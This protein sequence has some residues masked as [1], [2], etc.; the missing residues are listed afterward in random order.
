M[1]LQDSMTSLNPAFTIGD[2]VAEPIR[3][4]QKIE[5]GIVWQKVIDI[6]RLVRI[7]AAEKR[8]GE[9]PHQMSGGMRQRVSGA[10]AFSCQPFLLI[11]DEPTTS[12]DATIQAQYLGLLKEIQLQS[13]ISMIFVTHDFGIVAR[14]C[15]RVAVM[16][17]GKIVETAET[18][19][20]FNNP[21]HPYTQALMNCLPTSD[22]K[23]RRLGG[24]KGEP[25]NLACLPQGCIFEPR[26]PEREERCVFEYPPQMAVAK[27]HYASCW[28]VQGQNG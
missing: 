9:Y 4:H 18:R 2:Q 7:P 25:P 14:M 27:Y 17:A 20:L 6:L 15:N 19:E 24:I 13:R 12:L 1:I 16:Y 8:L 10:I 21:C 5:K 23:S 28:K 11:A 3:L 26:C 22:A